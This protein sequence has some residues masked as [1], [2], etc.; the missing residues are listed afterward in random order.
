MWL[1]ECPKF[2]QGQ[3]VPLATESGAI[4]LFCDE[5]DH[6]WLHP[7][8]VGVVEPIVTR[9]PEWIVAE[10]VH[11]KPGTTRYPTVAEVEALDW[12]VEWRA[13]PPYYPE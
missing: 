13:G 7:G 4:V 3:L 12:Q 5:Q 2:C 1:C 9:G 11:I 8:D 6:V 10:G